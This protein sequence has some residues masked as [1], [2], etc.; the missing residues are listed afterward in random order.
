MFISAAFGAVVGA[1]HSAI[2]GLA[3][4]LTPVAG[5]L[6]VALAIVLFTLLVRLLISPLTYVQVRGE[7]RRAALAPHLAAL[8]EKHGTDRVALAAATMEVHREHGVSMFAGLLPGLAQAPFFMVMY[9]V[10]AHAPAGAVFG[11]PL[12]AHAAAGWPVFAV[13]LTL[14]TA[15]AWWSVRRMSAASRQ[16]DGQQAGGQQAGGQQA[17]GQADGRRAGGQGAGG[18]R[19]GGQRARGQQSGGQRA[20]GGG[21]GEGGVGGQRARGGR[22]RGQQAGGGRAGGRRVAAPPAAPSQFAFLRYLPYFTVVMV[23]WLPLAG[24]LYLVTSTAWTALE[25]AMWRRPVTTGNR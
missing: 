15:L 16:A 20:G 19:D 22:A 17:G 5:S 11:V 10:A 8:G 4:L 1:A 25:H 21:V 18:Q 14:A 12:T 24:A 7:R 2:E 9:R 6:A 3:V 23:A 13:L